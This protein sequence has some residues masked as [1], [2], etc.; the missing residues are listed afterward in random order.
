MDPSKDF[1]IRSDKG[2]ALG[3]YVTGYAELKRT[4][5]IVDGGCSSACTLVL[6]N[7]DVCTTAKGF[8]NFHAATTLNGDPAPG[9]TAY[10]MK[11]YPPRVRD[12]INAN[13]GLTSEWIGT[14]ATTFLPLC[15][16]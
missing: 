16:P 5:I 14:K 12:W 11:V 7:A 1:V 15:A 3:V 6:V 2:G 8:F 4:H 10:L 13:G 9:S